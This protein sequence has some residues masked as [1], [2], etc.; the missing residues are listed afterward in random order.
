MTTPDIDGFAGR[1]IGPSVDEQAKMLAVVGHG[2]RADL[3]DHA[4]PAAIHQAGLDLPPAADEE[5]VLA[6]LRA[7][8]GQNRVV[9]SMI[10]LGYHDTVTPPVIRRGV[11]ENPG[12]YTAYTP[13]QPEISQGRLEA[14]LNFQTVV[15]DLT[16]LA[17]AN[18]SLLDEPTAAAEAMSLCRRSSK[19]TSTRFLVDAD[20]HPQT[21]AVLQTRAEPVGIDV[22][23]ADLS[24]G[25]PDADLFGVLV[26]FPGSSGALRDMSSL[27]TAAHDA[28]ALVAVTTDLLALTL[29]TPPGEWGADIAVGS[30]Q[31][32]GVPLGFGGPHAGFMAVRSGLE[33]GL[34]GRLV[35]V[36]VDTDGAP[37][38]RLA[39]QTREQHIRRE[40]A[41]SNICTAQVLLAVLAGMYAVYHGPDGLTAIARQVHARAAGL[42]A[43]L[44]ESGVE[45]TA[46]AF[47]DTV[48]A[49]VPG[50]AREVVEAALQRGVNLRLVDHDH[51]GISA[52]EKT[53]AD[54]VAAVCAAFGVAAPADHE[55]P[56]AIGPELR[57]Q[58]AFLTHPV[59]TAHRS[60]T[61]MMR[62][63][64]RL[65]DRDLALDRTMIPLGSCTMKLNAAAEM[66][67]IS[68]PEFAGI[69]PFAPLDQAGGH[70]AII[71][72][73]ET[74]LAEITGYDAVSLQP[75]AGSQGEF[76]GLLAIRAY[77]RDQGRPDRDICLIPSSAHGTN[78]ASAA[79]AGMRVVVVACDAAG[80]VSLEDLRGKLV[81]HGSRVA[82]LMVTYPSTHGVF[83]GDIADI[84]AAVH[85]A[86]GQVYVD[87]ANLNALVGL[88]KP[89]RFGADV[90]HL[91]LHKTFCIPHGGGGPG[92]GPVAVRAYLVPYLPNHPLVAEAG[93]STGVGPIA[94]APWGSAG[95]LPIPWAYIR[96]M[97]PDG[98]T[99]A[100]EVAVLAAN[101]VAKQLSPHYP[102][103]YTGRGGLVAHECIVD[104]RPITKETG[105]TVEDVAKRLIDYGFHA[106]TMS[107]PVAGTL[108]IEP[109]ESEDLAELDRFCDAMIA[110]RAEIEK[111]AS[112]EW[113]REDNPLR[114]SPHTA[115]MLVGEWNHPYSREVAAYPVASLRT[116]KYWPP[117]RRVDQGYGDRNLMC[118]CPPLSAYE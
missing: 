96:L 83:E 14:L 100:T 106:P 20:C 90:S 11:L 41:T 30:A 8:A 84:C 3:I 54:D 80:N 88:A 61:A 79:M 63:L 19:A 70:L 22:V 28:G 94:G 47:F 116:D 60:E 117:V 113:P 26:A 35:G 10:G 52:D 17:V 114:N 109:T 99:Q 102:V 12:W 105:V 34:P 38:Y 46:E 118:S 89:G 103:L 43:A 23:V 53:S 64:R 27:T 18:A 56:V 2:S 5:A 37:A 76:A 57:R 44:R 25:L 69:H 73:L 31:R 77:L 101:Y 45:L 13:Y 71:H 1:H 82:A 36:S 65:S 95:I 107:F 7:L 85:D 78:A 75:N 4:V 32:F 42:G 40:K 112:G 111:V 24:A 16:G 55:T 62:Y 58:S 98:L 67:P 86:G 115:A 21:I 33:R 39:L 87:G 50:R 66:E 48:T 29:L 92:V 6:E 97:G 59:F 49:R 91:N 74:W 81:E 72:D 108:M 93:P 104:V 9:R 15:S 51:V 68:W 110:I